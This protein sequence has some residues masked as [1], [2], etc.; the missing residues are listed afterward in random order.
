[1]TE[2]IRRIPT[3]NSERADKKSSVRVLHVDDETGFLGVSKQILEG[4]GPFQV[5]SASSVKEALEKMREKEFDVIVADY[6]MPIK[7][8]LQ[9]LKDLRKNGDNT[10]FILFTGKGR[11]DVAIKA[12]N[13][14]ADY[15]INKIGKPETVYGELTYGILQIVEKQKSELML[16]ES[17]EKFRSLA[18][19]SPIGIFRSDL[20]G[21]NTYAN[22]KVCEFLGMKPKDILGAGFFMEICGRKFFTGESSSLN[23]DSRGEIDE[24][25]YLEQCRRTL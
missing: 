19:S 15:Y 6:Q 24:K 18:S 2:R 7:D 14:G 4:Q 22:K 5:D 9:F 25:L 20:E 3:T 8:G 10:P 21:N 12:L 16:K 11:E 13:M 23:I 17:E 1:M